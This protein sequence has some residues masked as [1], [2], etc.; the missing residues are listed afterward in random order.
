MQ[1]ST[2]MDMQGV[3]PESSSNPAEGNMAGSFRCKAG[4]RYSHRG[5]GFRV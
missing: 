4:V 5:L 1:S 2:C 3:S